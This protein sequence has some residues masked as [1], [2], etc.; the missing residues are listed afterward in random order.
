MNSA[1]RKSLESKG[2][3]VGSVQKFLD[4]SPEEAKYIELKIALGKNYKLI[5]KQSVSRKRNL[6]EELNRVSRGWRKWNQV[7]LLFRLT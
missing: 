4:L 5:E 6:L 7:I 3:K 1:K 2:F